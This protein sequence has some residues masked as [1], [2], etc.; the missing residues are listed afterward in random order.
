M[1]NGF[2][3]SFFVVRKQH[4]RLYAMTEIDAMTVASSLSK[5][6]SFA[7]LK[8]L[9]MLSNIGHYFWNHCNAIDATPNVELTGIN[10]GFAVPISNIYALI[11]KS[12][13]KACGMSSRY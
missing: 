3:I 2:Y 5:F 6:H 9:T 1:I 7:S 12:R 8:N 10:G 11:D 4:K 13:N